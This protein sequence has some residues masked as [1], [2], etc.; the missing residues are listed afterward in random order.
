MNELSTTVETE[1]GK[2]LHLFLN[3]NH[4]S[5]IDPVAFYS[6]A[7]LL[8]F[9]GMAFWVRIVE[10]KLNEM[11]VKYNLL[12]EKYFNI[13]NKLNTKLEEECCGNDC[14]TCPLSDQ[15]EQNNN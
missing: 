15:C 8:L 4:D 2:E 9:I 7:F 10:K 6:V 1:T 11:I 5:L 12:R 14:A 13:E 3:V